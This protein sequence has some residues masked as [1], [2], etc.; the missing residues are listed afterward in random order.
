MLLRWNAD[1]VTVIDIGGRDLSIIH[2]YLISTA[3]SLQSINH[4]VVLLW[5]LSENTERITE[6]KREKD[7]ICMSNY[8]VK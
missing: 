5:N 1:D 2:S 8:F 4:S 3:A 6:T 7:T